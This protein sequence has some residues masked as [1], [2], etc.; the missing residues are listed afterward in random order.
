MKVA[1]T[2]IGLG[3]TIALSSVAVF[4]SIVSSSD[5]AHA[6]FQVCNRS[7]ESAVV[8]FAYLEINGRNPD[9][10]GVAPPELSRGWNS[11]G[12]WSL[13]PG[14]CVQTYPHELRARN[15]IYYVYAQGNRGGEWSGSNTFCTIP[16]EFTLGN[17][18]K[19]C[20]NG[21]EWKKF[22]EV[23]TGDAR[24]FTYKLQD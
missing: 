18:N 17:A 1:S 9:I 10:F 22:K 15:S 13:K 2:L 21:G 5:P 19:V 12:W 16:G 14:K 20:G 7:T 24:N 4:T 8:A 23:S 11:E 6:W 3:R